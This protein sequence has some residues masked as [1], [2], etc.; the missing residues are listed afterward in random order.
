MGV[1]LSDRRTAEEMSLGT[2]PALS[3][4]QARDAWRDA[5]K[6]AQTG[7]DPSLRSQEIGARDF[8][9]I[10]DEWL[11]RDQSQNRSKDSTKRL[12]DHNV[13]PLWQQR[14]ISEIKRPDIMHALDKI[15]DRGSPIA[16]RR[17][18]AHLHRFFKW[19]VERGYI[20]ISPMMHLTKPGVETK[21]DRVLSDE[22]LKALWSKAEKLGWPFGR[23]MQLLILTGARRQE[24]AGLRRSELK[25]DT[26]EL[27]GARTKNGKAHIIPLSPPARA[28]LSSVPRIEGSVFIF[29]TN[30]KGP[31]VA[32]ASI[33]TKLDG[34]LPFT[35]WR[36]HDL[37]RTVATGLQKLGTPL[38]VTEAILGHTAGSRGGIVGVYQGYDYAHEKRAGGVGR[39]CHGV[40]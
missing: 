28:M 13:T 40:D 23:A 31:V 6:A 8:A 17:L 39:A 27:G 35:D 30:G 34:E 5:R 21:R 32:W 22:E 16:A 9:N 24:I 11:K 18:H 4:A 12:I 7:R 1:L 36:I 29:T 33:K 2:Y 25:G 20:E 37:R 14:L 19:C 38:Q 26:I 10:L 3:L 15:V